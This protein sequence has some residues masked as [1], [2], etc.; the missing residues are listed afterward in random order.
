V[1]TAPVRSLLLADAAVQPLTIGGW[2][3]AGVAKDAIQALINTL[4][5]IAD[6][7]IW[8]ALY[9]LPVALVLFI[10][11]WLVWLGIKRWRKSRRNRIVETPTTS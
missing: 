3:P 7:T 5:G 6:G 9:L 8:L 11:L 2:E 10:P 1:A 4:Q